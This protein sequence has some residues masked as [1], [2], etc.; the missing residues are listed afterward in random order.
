MSTY[1]EIFDTQLDPD[2]PITSGLGYQFRENPIAIAEGASGAPK[3][4]MK[5]VQGT[6]A[7]INFT[8]L[9]DFNGIWLDFYATES[10][11]VG[12]DITIALS[13]D[14]GSSYS[15]ASIV[16]VIPPGASWLHG[17]V[18]VEFDT[19]WSNSAYGGAT[20]ASTANP[21]VAVPVGTVNAVRLSSSSTGTVYI[22]AMANP[23]GGRTSS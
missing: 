15:S 6:G 1:N 20:S 7:T 18:F 14:N 8:G 22:A 2:A 10:G 9:D 16:A 23:N 13:D 3:I 11:G 21:T 12:A 17:T 4:A 5:V 19:G